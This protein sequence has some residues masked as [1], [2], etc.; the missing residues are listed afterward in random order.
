MKYEGIYSG[1]DL[2]Y[3]GN[4]RQL[5]MTLSF[6]RARTHVVSVRFRGAKRMRRDEHGDLVLQTASR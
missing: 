6:L 2:V 3:Y 1:I 5:D 4:E